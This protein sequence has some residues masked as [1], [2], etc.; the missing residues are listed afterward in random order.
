MIKKIIF[1]ACLATSCVFAQPN[2]GVN[3]TSQIGRY[4]ITAT[5]DDLFLLETDTGK[6]WVAKKFQDPDPANCLTRWYLV[7]T[8]IPKN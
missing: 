3:N 2:L 6:I 7:K 1:L 5:E 4:Q 8:Q